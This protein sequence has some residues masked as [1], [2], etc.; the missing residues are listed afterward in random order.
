MGTMRSRKLAIGRLFYVR[1]H[2][3]DF[4]WKSLEDLSW[5][6]MVPVGREFGSPD[7][8]RL[9]ALDA[10]EWAEHPDIYRGWRHE[11]PGLQ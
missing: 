6:N 11:A 3:P 9:T 2:S 10:I 4:R 7:Y 8:E 5:D 1:F